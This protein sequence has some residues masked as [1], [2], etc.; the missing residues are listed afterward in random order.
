MADQGPK[1]LEKPLALDNARFAARAS[2]RAAPIRMDRH[3][4]CILPPSPLCGP[5]RRSHRIPRPFPPASA[6]LGARQS[7]LEALVLKRRVMGPGWLLLRAPKRREGLSMVRAGR[8]AGGGG[9][10][11]E[12]GRGGC[13]TGLD[14]RVHIG[15]CMQLAHQRSSGPCSLRD[16]RGGRCACRQILTNSL[17]KITRH[18]KRD[19]INQ[20]RSNLPQVS[21]CKMEVELSG[22]KALL[23]GKHAGAAAMRARRPPPPLTVA[24]LTLRLHTDARTQ[25]PEILAASVVGGAGTHCPSSTERFGAGALFQAAPRRGSSLSHPTLAPPQCPSPSNSLFTHLAPTPPPTTPIHSAR[26][27]SRASSRTP[28]CRATSGTRR[29]YCA[30]SRLCGSWTGAPGRRVSHA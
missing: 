13:L 4:C 19:A 30:T 16:T 28:P 21:W 14:R 18:S 29:S 5:T 17:Q 7:P 9:P 10:R 6:I 8:G 2:R 15:C 11:S 24:A 20:N 12:A 27:T 1:L 23:A 26:Y 22:P 25:Q 3:A